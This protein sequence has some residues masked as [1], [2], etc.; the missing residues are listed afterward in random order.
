MYVQVSCYPLGVDVQLMPGQPLPDPGTVP[1]ADG[2][3]GF[4]MG[5]AAVQHSRPGTIPTGLAG[6]AESAKRRS[7]A[8]NCPTIAA[9]ACESSHERLR[10]ILSGSYV[11]PQMS[12]TGVDSSRLFL[13]SARPTL[14]RRARR[15]IAMLLW[16]V[17]ATNAA[18]VVWL[19]LHG[20][21]VSRVH[22]S[23]ELFTSLGRITG[24]VAVYLALI[25]IL[26]L[27]RLPP[28]ERLVGFDRLT[29]WHRRNGK[30]CISLVVAH[31]VLITVGYA[32][33]DQVSIPSEFS[34]LVSTYPGMVTATIG[35]ALMIGVVVSS[36]VIVRRRLPYEGWYFVH[37]SIYAGIALSYLHQLPTGNEFT[38]HRAQAN[39]W[40]ALY[41]VTLVVLVCFRLAAPA[42]GAFRYRLRVAEVTREGPGV[43]SLRITGRH[44][45]RLNARAGQFMLW[46]F[47]TRGR[48]WQAHPFSLSAAPDGHSLRLTVKDV[49]NFTSGIGDLSPGTAVL[50]EG[51]FGTFTAV[52]RTRPRVA[53]I[54]GGI[55]ITPIRALFEE[56]PAAPGELALIYRVMCDEELVFR[57]ELEEIARARG[58]DLFFIV[59]DHRSVAGSQLLSSARLRQLIPD[60]AEREVYLCGPHAM[61]IRTE[62]SLRGAGVPAHQIHSE[63]FALAA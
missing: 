29:V 14:G 61:M 2:A 45:D 52:R 54:A 25:Q 53:L 1:L 62:G 55:G 33:S 51:P 39:Y 4:Q 30:V 57:S 16:L 17:A 37:L 44:L 20:G 48:W 42:F 36:L 10:C 24:L 38:T 46:R 58:A 7:P 41:V 35:T 47:F 56:L 8:A 50:A 11:V 27:S 31:T 32:A 15:A 43:V 9:C 23:A 40:I 26:L 59:G 5:C 18:V 34:R 49:G 13:P 12:A 28:L 6:H 63:R 21:G 60:I 22:G 19:W 3:C